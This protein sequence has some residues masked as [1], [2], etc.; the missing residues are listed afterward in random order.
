MSYNKKGWFSTN[1]VYIYLLAKLAVAL[2]A[3]LL[4]QLAFALFNQRIFCHTLPGEWW[5]LTRGNIRFGIATAAAVLLPYFFVM[6][7]PLNLRWKGWYR[8]IA[9]V[10]YVVP[11]LFVLVANMCDCAYFQFTYRRLSSEI[12]L[13]LTIGGDMGS[14]VPHF[15]VDFWRVELVG[16]GIIVLFLILSAKTRLLER[17]PYADHRV[18]DLAGFLFGALV[19]FIML[20]G[21]FGKTIQL[22]DASRYCQIQ[23]SALVNNSAYTIL[24][25]LAANDIEE[26]HY[27]SDDEA[28][29][30]FDPIYSPADRPAT[31]RPWGP[32]AGVNT[33]TTDSV[34]I[35][36]RKNVVFIILESFSQ[37][38]MGCYNDS[39]ME[40]FTPFLDE[41]AQ[42]GIAYNGLSNGKKSIEAIPSVLASLP[43]LS[44]KPFIMTQ[45]MDND[46]DALP[47]ILQRNGYRTAFFHGSY[48]GS[49]NFDK[50]CAKAGFQD[51][52]GRNEYAAEYGD[53]T[54]YD[55][56][57]G[58]YDEPFLQF[59]A[60]KLGTFKEPFFATVFTI[61]SHHP[62]GIPERH[63]GEFR[64]GEHP[65]L[66]CVMYTDY[67]L[68]KFFENAARQPW[69]DNTLFVILA[70]HPGQGLHPEFN[71]HDGWYRIPMI[72]YTPDTAMLQM[73]AEMHR[74]QR[75]VQQ[76]DLMPT[77]LDYLAINEQ[78]VCFG[79]SLFRQKQGWQ[80]AYGSGY[81]QLLRNKGSEI[82]VTA[83]EGKKHIG[84]T[85]DLQFLQ[86]LLQ[87]YNNRMVH[88]QLTPQ[89]K[90]RRK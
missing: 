12:L 8:T 54:N 71:G 33:V 37:E 84:N 2:F 15:I 60:Q 13:Y 87:Q 40:S 29:S 78:A 45:Y 62:Y 74:S 34:A 79:Q 77:I 19:V 55:H 38:Y 51:Y 47:A 10:L 14:L 65:L 28:A 35:P 7:L 3:I 42:K 36:Q 70:D 24:R 67:A 49:M 66:Q 22:S 6:L 85:R 52:Y 21:G 23:N 5:G 88:N 32:G 26:T 58:I 9:E 46:I 76:A 72:V 11:M 82:E 81:Y 1:N 31:Q 44:E 86:S 83:T 69:Y 59:M 39:I 43:T 48:N 75:I 61:S 90:T 73:P 17:N 27:M 30:I 18:N 50:F 89:P 53:G 68:R 80:A 64:Q 20:R 25:T 57:W 41:L 4:T 63:K 56:A 16:I